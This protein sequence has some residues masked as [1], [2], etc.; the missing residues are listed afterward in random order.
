MSAKVV[1]IPPTDC[2]N[3]AIL[4]RV[5]PN[6]LKLANVVPVFKKWDSTIKD[7]YRLIKG[8]WKNAF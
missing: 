2:F 7:N 8:F 5:F 4:D 3:A 1:C 6:E